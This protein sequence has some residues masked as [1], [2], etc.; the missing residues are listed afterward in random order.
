MATP[1]TTLPKK[2]DILP[3]IR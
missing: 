1:K 2:I 3:T